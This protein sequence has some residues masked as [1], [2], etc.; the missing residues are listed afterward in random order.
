MAN[1]WNELIPADDDPPL[2]SW[3]TMSLSSRTWG[4]A[5]R[6][7]KYRPRA[8][9][10]TT[11]GRLHMIELAAVTNCSMASSQVADRIRALHHIRAT[12]GHP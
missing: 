1:D 12:P 6:I 10:P 3:P 5:M 11:M 4:A 7:V 8:R 2:T 9:S